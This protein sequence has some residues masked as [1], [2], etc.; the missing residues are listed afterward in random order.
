MT[1]SLD[2]PGHRDLTRTGD[3]NLNV[4]GPSRLGIAEL[5]LVLPRSLCDDRRGPWHD[6]TSVCPCG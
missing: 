3:R 5:D 2:V 4:D 1:W 6:S